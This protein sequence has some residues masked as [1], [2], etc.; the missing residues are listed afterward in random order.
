MIPYFSEE[1]GNPSSLYPL[2]E[3]AKDVINNSREYIRDF[4]NAPNSKVIFTSGGSESNSLTII[5]CADYLKKKGKTH[6]ITS[7]VEHKSILNSFKYLEDHGFDVTYLP[8]QADATVSLDILKNEITEKTGMVSLMLAN[9]ELGSLN[10]IGEIGEFLSDKDIIFHSDCVQG[11]TETDIDFQKLKVDMISISGHKI[12]APKGIG[13]LV[14]SDAKMPLSKEMKPIIFGGQQQYNLRGGTENVPYI[15]GI[16]SAL[17]EFKENN[18]IEKTRLLTENLV[19]KL[20]KCKDFS[21]KIHIN[22]QSNKIVNFRMDGVSAEAMELMLFN[23]GIFV[24]AGSACNSKSSEPSY[25]LLSAG[26]SRE[27]AFSSIR[28]SMSACNTLSEVD[29]FV[30]RLNENVK[31]LLNMHKQ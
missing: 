19:L 24:S 15:V 17:K 3:N 6:I 23:D 8:V 10:P 14:V 27:E 7:S 21:N 12:R 2:G 18:S 13:L 20:R 22:N 28:V 9:N 16:C 31:L 11:I 4:F 1:Y 26:L 5:G 30:K 25:V 29:E